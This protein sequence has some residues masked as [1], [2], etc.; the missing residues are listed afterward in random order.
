[1]FKI[2]ITKTEENY[3]FQKDKI[4]QNK[5][6]TLNPNQLHIFLKLQIILINK[7]NDKKIIEI[8]NKIISL[9]LI[10]SKI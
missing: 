10:N 2:L 7:K 6:N 3:Q 9:K 8:K 4:I 1:M 5:T